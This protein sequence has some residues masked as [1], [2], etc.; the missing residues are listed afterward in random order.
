MKNIIDIYEGILSDIE[1]TLLDTDSLI[2]AAAKEFNNIKRDAINPKEYGVTKSRQCI[3]YRVGIKADNLLK[4]MG[5]PK[6]DLLTVIIVKD[7]Y[8]K[9]WEFSVLAHS[10]KGSYKDNIC[11][12]ITMP[13]GKN[14]MSINKFI[15]KFVVPVFKDIN[16]LK[17]FIELNRTTYND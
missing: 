17:K 10:Y 2:D 4:L 9:R 5:Y 15:D 6:N 8:W 11:G 13:L 7:T 3:D 12:E 14:Q 1:D 16:S